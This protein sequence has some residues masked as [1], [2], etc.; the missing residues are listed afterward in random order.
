MLST[1]RPSR[2]T[3]FVVILCLSVACLTLLLLQ[4]HAPT[5]TGFLGT[6]AGADADAD[7]LL[8]A[9]SRARTSTPVWEPPMRA[10][11]ASARA[12]ATML[13]LA[14]NSDINGVVQSV[15]EA[16][17]RFN[18]AYGYPWVFLNEEPFSED[19]KNRVG[20]LIQGEVYFGQ[21]PHDHWYQ[22]DWIDEQRAA[23]G[24][25]QLVRQKVIYG[26]SVSYR[27]MCRFNS[28]FFFHHPLLQKYRWYW[29]VEPDVH[30]HCDMQ[31]DP[32][33]YMEEHN[34][35]YGFTITMLEFEKTIPTL[36]PAVREFMDANPQYIAPGNALDY[37]SYNRGETYNLCHFWSNFEIADLDFWRGE[38]YRKFFD[39]LDAKGGFYYERWGDAPVHSIAAALFLPKERIHFFR[40]IGYFHHPFTH[41]PVE[42]DIWQ[43]GRCSCN[44]DDSFDYTGYSCMRQW[45]RALAGLA[46]EMPNQLPG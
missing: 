1:Y 44:P 14:R 29:R 7:E 30:F 21:I 3:T 43:A 25:K 38:A 9:A 35:T 13:M 45:D 17:D 15:R 10:H 39:F 8:L 16:E 33:V 27:N 32:F 11:N 28:G 5:A 20:N 42:R 34:K 6:G 26:G 12:N 19:F 24:R 36:W 23:A 37:V 2:P 22:P 40:E 4:L 46:P 31:H 41:C 18:R